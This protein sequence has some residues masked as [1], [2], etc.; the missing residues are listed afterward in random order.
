MVSQ[1]TKDVRPSV[2]PITTETKNG[3]KTSEKKSPLNDLTDSS[4]DWEDPLT[5]IMAL[6][7]LEAW[8][9]FR[10]VEGLWWQVCP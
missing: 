3:K 1:I 6:E 7:K 8:I 10:I 5:F 9:F 2:E 4:D